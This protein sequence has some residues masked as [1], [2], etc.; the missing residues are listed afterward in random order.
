MSAREVYVTHTAAAFPNAPVGNDDIEDIL[1]RVHGKPSR[2]R[3]I[4]L[5]RNGI[6]RRFY[7]LDPATGEQTTTNAQLT[8]QA[9]RGLFTD[10]TEL[11]MVDCLALGTT[12]PDQIAPNHAVM[13]HGELGIP[14][15]EVV[16][17]SGICMSGVTALKYGYLAVKS[18]EAKC[19]VTG[20]SEVLSPLMLARNFEAEPSHRVD[21][22]TS[23][24]ELGFERDFLRWMLSDGAGV[25][26]LAD[27]P[28][29]QP[30]RVSLRLD[31]VD[32]VSY[33][34]QLETCMYMGARKNPDGSLEGW[35]SQ[36][37]Q[38]IVDDALWSLQQ[39][40]RL[41]NENIVDVTF[42]QHLRSI[43]ERRDIDVTAIN[44]FL[45]HISSMYFYDKVYHALVR[46]GCEIPRDRWFTNLVDVGNIGAASV[47]V[48]V[49]DLIRSEKLQPGDSVLCFVPES[50]RFSSSFMHMT[51]VS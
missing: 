48:M 3:K 46:L 1:G 45:P 32:V 11:E 18:G 4:V 29:A 50:G 7:A 33:A 9:I 20:G 25:F 21:A 5:K 19:A 35:V 38:K 15:C 30:G 51:A 37:R 42:T 28:S 49:D 34:N 12:S 40:V 8:A 16:G 39:D 2:A 17:T 26:A 31:W 22:L 41:L 47:F 14:P 6:K 24:P 44:H 43:I 10:P 23:Q 36:D 27:R 13:V